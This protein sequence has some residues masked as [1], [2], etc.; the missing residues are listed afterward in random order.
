MLSRNSLDMFSTVAPQDTLCVS[1]IEGL[2]DCRI[3]CKLLKNLC[4]RQRFEAQSG[5]LLRPILKKALQYLFYKVAFSAK[6]AQA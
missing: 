3:D 6:L 4:I 5:F 2:N 1:S